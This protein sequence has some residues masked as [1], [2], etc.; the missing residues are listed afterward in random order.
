MI[1]GITP[2]VAGAR[3]EKKT[4]VFSSLA[5]LA[6]KTNFY[7]YTF[8]A[9]PVTN[10]HW[11]VGALFFLLWRAAGFAGLHISF[12]LLCLAAFFVFFDRARREAGTGIAAAIAVPVIFL[13]AERTEV[14]P[15]ILS[16]LFCGIFIRVLSRVRER[17][18]D[19][20]MLDRKSVV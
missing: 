13:L 12:L 8:P 3:S 5:R 2:F 7:S 6:I 10:H 1:K 17:P 15:E 19:R 18:G 16:Y 4:A 20:H 14:R 9:F 11:L